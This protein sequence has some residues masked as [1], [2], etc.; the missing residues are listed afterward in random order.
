LKIQFIMERKAWWPELE[1]DGVTHGGVSLWGAERSEW[2]NLVSFLL[3][4][5]SMTTP[6]IMVLLRVRVGPSLPH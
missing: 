4:T 2:W 6:H 5:Q 3:S 1:A